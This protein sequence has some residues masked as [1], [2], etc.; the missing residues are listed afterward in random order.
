[1]CADDLVCPADVIASWAT[2]AFAKGASI[3]EFEPSWYFFRLPR[4]V[5]GS[6][7]DDYTQ[8]P[9]WANRGNAKPDFLTLINSL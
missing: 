6:G 9:A 3:V 5:I 1:M 2:Q 8:D 4:G 7:V